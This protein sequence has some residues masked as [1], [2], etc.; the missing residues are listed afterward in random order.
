MVQKQWQVKLQSP[1]VNQGSS[2]EHLV[3]LIDHIWHS[4]VLEFF[5]FNDNFT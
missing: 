2:T 1:T 5:F 4:R 3:V